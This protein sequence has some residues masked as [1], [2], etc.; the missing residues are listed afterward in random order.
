MALR[1]VLRSS[2]TVAGDDTTA[3]LSASL[4]GFARGQSRA[5]FPAAPANN[6]NAKLNSLGHVVRFPAKAAV[7]VSNLP[8]PKQFEL[9]A[10]IPTIAPKTKLAS[11]DERTVVIKNVSYNLSEDGMASE[12][13]S[14]GFA[15]DSISYAYDAAG[16]FRGIAFLRFSTVEEAALM[17]SACNG[18]EVAGRC[19]TVEPYEKNRAPATAETAGSCPIAIS[20]SSSGSP[21]SREVP[22]EVSSRVLE[23][24]R[25][26]EA[27]LEG[28]NMR[29]KVGGKFGS[30]TGS[31]SSLS[32][33]ASW[34]STSPSGS[35]PQRPAKLFMASAAAGGKSSVPPFTPPRQPKGPDG[36]NGFSFPRSIAIAVC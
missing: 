18:I 5:A 3:R 19:W 28:M 2:S 4:S 8:A 12:L 20:R 7:Q 22:A 15:P 35:P 25:M 29:V 32:P 23:A 26:A 34:R 6:F 11:R 14:R 30:P 33:S 16:C 36:S 13:L 21:I 24:I 9:D 31:S 1:R 27:T 10:S 17:V